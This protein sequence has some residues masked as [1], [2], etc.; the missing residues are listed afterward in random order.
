MAGNPRKV[1][2]VKKEGIRLISAENIPKIAE[3]I[4]TKYGQEIK[5]NVNE[6]W[7]LEKLK[8]HFD[9]YL[10][11]PERFED[12]KH[13][14]EEAK[15][16]Q[17][18]SHDDYS[19]YI[20]A[21]S[22]R[23][24]LRAEID[25]FHVDITEKL[26]EFS[27][28]LLPIA[29]KVRAGKKLTEE[30]KQKLGRIRE[31]FSG[32]VKNFSSYQRYLPLSKQLVEDQG[33]FAKEHIEKLQYLDKKISEFGALFNTL[34]KEWK[35]KEEK[36]EEERKKAKEMSKKAEEIFEAIA[37]GK[38]PSRPSA[39]EE[40]EKREEGKKPEEVSWR[41]QMRKWEIETIG[42]IEEKK[43]E[44]ETGG[45]PPQQPKQPGP[46][47]PKR[48]EEK[49]EKT[50]RVPIKVKVRPGWFR[51]SVDI[52]VDRSFLESIAEGAKDRKGKEL[53]DYFK[54]KYTFKVGDKE[55]AIPYKKLV[56]LYDKLIASERSKKKS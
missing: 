13:I 48:E 15:E 22:E 54:N 46:E 16:H 26:K 7:L 52:P 51:R 41:E 53:K 8:P 55:V 14:L 31:E 36:M 38:V 56:E 9:E 6:E 11:K 1:K 40:V 27:T 44:G 49:K 43:K 34:E 18:I 30:E 50:A 24:K 45:K 3:F 2:V 37:R 12:I 35:V 33:I 47:Q 39:P 17:I 10:R 29:E 32:I 25:S 20:K 28:H 4:K 21:I 19:K 5:G 42:E 23:I